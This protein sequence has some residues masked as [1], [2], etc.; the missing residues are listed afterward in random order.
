MMY[1]DRHLGIHVLFFLEVARWLLDTLTTQGE[2]Q[3]HQS[4]VLV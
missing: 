4:I 1:F 2:F 3:L